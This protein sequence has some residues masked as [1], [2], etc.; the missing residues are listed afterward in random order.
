MA[1]SV[2]NIDNHTALLIVDVQTWIFER[3]DPVYNKDILIKNIN[4]LEE[5]AHSNSLPV[6]YIQ[7]ESS[8]HLM[9]KS[10]GWKLHKGLNPQSNDLFIGK[11]KGNAF[12][13]TSLQTLLEERE[14]NRVLICGLLSQ[15][16]ILKTTIGALETGYETILV[17]D[18]HSNSG[19]YPLKNITMVH[20]KVKKAGGL[21]MSTIDIILKQ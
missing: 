1:T 12:L 19:M 8:G 2:E 10:P 18:A 13:E 5:Y 21:L 14:I 17:T 3:Q 11:R 20:N 4:L 9:K 16:C 15:Q 7:H 6:T